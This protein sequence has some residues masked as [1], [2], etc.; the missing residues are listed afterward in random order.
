MFERCHPDAL[1]DLSIS[2]AKLMELDILC[3]G[4]M[5]VSELTSSTKIC[6]GDLINLLRKA[7]SLAMETVEGTSYTLDRLFPEQK[8]K[9]ADRK[10]YGPSPGTVRVFSRDHIAYYTGANWRKL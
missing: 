9:K 4:Y 3:G 6:Y 1:V 5:V 10:W 2:Y 7:E 8:D